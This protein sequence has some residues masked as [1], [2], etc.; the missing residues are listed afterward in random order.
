MYIGVDYYPEHWPRERWATDARL[1]KEAGFNIVRLAEFA[2][3]VMEP[4]EGRYD[5]SLFDEAIRILGE[6][7]I[8]VILG[9][10][11][12][13]MPAWV[14]RKYPECL[15]V[16]A[17]GQSRNWGVRKNNSFT[18]GT[19]RFL[20]ER[21]T[22]AMAEHYKSNPH[23]IGWQTD[24][25]F[26]HGMCYSVTSRAEFQD[27][28]RAKYKTLDAFNAAMGTHFW[29]HTYGTWGEIVIPEDMSGQNPSL[30]LEWWRFHSWITN[31]FQHDQVRI[32]REVCPHHFVTHNLMGFAPAINYYTLAEDLDFVSWDNYPGLNAPEIH[33][34]AGAA[35]DL[36]RSVKH[37]NFWV[38]E[39]SAGPAGWGDFGR[40]LRPG[41]LRKIS[42]QQVAHGAD[43][44]VWFRWRTCTAGREQYWHGLL[45]HDGIAGR[46][47]EEAAKT[48]KEY[49]R[50]APELEG[51]T[52]K[53]QVA[54]L[55]D[56]DTILAT[57]TQ[58]GHPDALLFKN[59][60]KPYYDALFRAGVNVEFVKPTD[61]L[62]PYK[63]LLA[64]GAFIM[65]DELAEK[66]NRFVKDGGVFFA[67]CR[68]GVKNETNLCHPRTLP[69]LLSESLGITIPE[70]ESV[71]GFWGFSR[72]K[73]YQLAGKGP[74]QGKYTGTIFSDWVIA[75]GAETLV[76][77]DTTH[78]HME[79]YAAVTKHAYGKGHGFYAGTLVAEDAFHDLLAAE[80]L[81]TA[82]IAPVIKP[83][84]GV[85]V[86]VR[87]GQGKKLL[88]LINHTEEPQTVSVPANCAE[89]ISGR[90]TG[91]KWELDRYEVAVVKLS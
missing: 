7:S 35:A 33:Y 40:N 48:T 27:W 91:E 81:T 49:H 74:L 71:G 42:Y 59:R 64:P 84:V 10:P 58:P 77:Y 56:Y 60:L 89:L 85:E 22:R 72:M 30:C 16:Q 11:T 41:E 34:E 50:L 63:L 1:M 69:G 2:W 47:Y 46:R 4:E 90:T 38:M 73:D 15:A 51:T 68:T 25:E 75:Q 55:Y 45:G 13:V 24:N 39:Q 32:L 65:P 36:M 3:V 19:Y 82:Q 86:S 54:I 5:F 20:S 53:A 87:E 76:A 18:A 67:D 29:G 43:G 21:I 12:G 37:K 62:S 52:V 14:A 23:V 88:F 17:N 57:M 28:L 61:D 6:Q 66:I 83:P 44:Q 70:Y 9:T 79:K 31:R 26:D 8:S 80:L 78:W